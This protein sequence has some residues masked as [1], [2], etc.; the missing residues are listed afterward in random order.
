M[1]GICGF[2]NLDNSPAD[3]G[4]VERMNRALTHRGPDG[5]GVLVKGPAAIAM[6]RLAIIDIEG[7]RQP[8][9]N[10]DNTVWIVFNGEIYNS[11]R[12]KQE[13]ESLGHRFASHCDTETIIH[14]YEETGPA[15]TDALGGMFA[16]AILD[17]RAAMTGRRPAL[18]LARDRPGIKPLFYYLD[19]HV[20]AFSSELTSL[21]QH[22]RIERE[23]ERAGLY[24]YLAAG[25]VAAPLTLFKNVRQLLPGQRLLLRPEGPVLE[26]YWQPPAVKEGPP[27]EPAEAAAQLRR[28]L[29][30]TV[31]E[32]LLS[33]VP[34]GA[35]LSGGI[36]S[37]TVVALMAQAAGHPVPTFSIRF[38]EAGYDESTFAR[39]VAERYGTQH[40][41]FTVPNRGFDAELLQT[42]ITHHGQPTGDSSALP[43]FIVSRLAREH[44]KVVLSGDGGDESFAGYYHYGWGQQIDRLYRYPYSMR[45]LAVRTLRRAAAWPRLTQLDLLRQ[46][47]NAVEVSLEEQALVPLELLRFNDDAEVRQLLAPE[48]QPAG[49]VLQ[50]ELSHFLRAGQQPD[51]LN[52]ALRFS[53]RYYL[54]DAYLAKVD[55]MSMAN[56]LEV[57]VPL[58]DHRLVEFSLSLP[59]AM[60]W[61]GGTGKQLLRRA[62]ADLLPEEI[63]TH[64]K[65]GFSIP[66]H[67]WVTEAYYDLAE[68]LLNE[69]S[70]RQRGLF[71]PAAVRGLLDRCRGKQPHHRSLESDHRLSHRLFMLVAL[72]LWCR[73][74]LDDLVEHPTE[75]IRWE[76]QVSEQVYG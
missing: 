1:C 64:R 27:P 46:A 45:R 31:R 12:L 29:E 56:A 52:Q 13:L 23:I 65:Q 74:Y 32:H 61:R 33:D 4:I 8:M 76:G 62:V 40:H 22:P 14:Q 47:I 37:S 50:P 20:L 10:E 36:D 38:E 17:Q 70:V 69:T 41:E 68:E 55:R 28:L 24:Q 49:S 2:I 73:L 15:C 58:L 42:I 18:L 7:G 34:V 59:G 48:W 6:R 9:S 35:F 26:T 11:P 16:F 54:P 5:G 63:F 53:F 21:V 3:P 43:T 57:R 44:V 51:R 71:N 60:H 25:A 75:A 72:E 67:R 39:L 30:D 66:L 19:D